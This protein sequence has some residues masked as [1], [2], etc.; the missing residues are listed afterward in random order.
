MISQTATS[1][2]WHLELFSIILYFEQKNSGGGS[3]RTN[4]LRR[5]RLEKRLAQHEVA[6]KMGVS[7]SYYSAIENGDKP[8]SEMVEAARAVNKMRTRTDR[9]SG[10]DLKAGRRR[11]K[12]R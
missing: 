11:R 4:E 5:L 9:T 1:S 7:Q 12:R 2:G 3:M 8:Q 10:G 6:K